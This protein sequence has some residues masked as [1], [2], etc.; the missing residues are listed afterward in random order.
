MRWHHFPFLRNRV[1]SKFARERMA[2]QQP[3]QSQP[4]PAHCSKSFNRLIRIARTRRLK[5]A[6]S[7]KQNRQVRFVEAQREQRCTHGNGFFGHHTLFNTRNKSAVSA[8]NSAR[9]TEFFG[10]MTM[11]HPAVISTRWHP[12]TS[13]N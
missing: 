5:A 2:A 3:F 6:T 7:R 11:S 13:R 10:G 1:I 9:A 4:N 12:T 8:A